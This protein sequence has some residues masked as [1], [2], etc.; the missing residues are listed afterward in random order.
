MNQAHVRPD[1]DVALIVRLNIEH[2]RKRLDNEIDEM[3]QRTIVRLL[4]D[5]EAKLKQLVR[6]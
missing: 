1:V 2:Y 6:H 3:T 5:E 4:S